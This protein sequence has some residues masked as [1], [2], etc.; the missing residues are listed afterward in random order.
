[1]GGRSPEFWIPLS[2]FYW[3]ELFSVCFARSPTPHPAYG[4]LSQRLGKRLCANI[5]YKCLS[6]LNSPGGPRLLHNRVARIETCSNITW[7]VHVASVCGGA[8]GHSA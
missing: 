4:A 6:L 5:L 2:L 3:P 7:K 8:I 1:M